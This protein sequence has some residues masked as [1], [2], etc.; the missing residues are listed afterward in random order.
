MAHAPAR[1]T[2]LTHPLALALLRF[3]VL[4]SLLLHPSRAGG[5]PVAPQDAPAALHRGWSARL[6]EELRLD[7]V[8]SMDDPALPLA[9]LP[10]ELFSRLVLYGGIAL[11]ASHIRRAISRA[12]VVHLMDQLGDE[13]MAFARAR[14]GQGLAALPVFPGWSADRARERC[15]HWGHALLAQA[16]AAA[17]PAVAQRGA[18]RLPADIEPR[19]RQVDGAGLA[20]ATA[21]ALAREFL[22]YLEPQWLS[23]FPETR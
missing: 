21:L 15:T 6:L 22:E 3:N 1:L 23:S 8:L 14:H 13:G 12:D 11:N 20:P 5:W 10:P 19:R 4:P 9:M 18:L 16:F 2:W 7:P 17:T